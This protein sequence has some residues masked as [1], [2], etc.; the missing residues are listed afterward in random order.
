LELSSTRRSTAWRSDGATPTAPG[1]WALAAD[2]LESATVKTPQTRR[3]LFTCASW[4]VGCKPFATTVTPRS[5]ESF[6]ILVVMASAR[7][8]ADLIQGHSP[9]QLIEPVLDDRQRPGRLIDVP[10]HHESLSIRADVVGPIRHRR[11]A[12][13]V[14]RVREQP[15]ARARFEL[16][17]QLDGHRDQSAGEITVEELA[18]VTGPRRLA[19]TAS[20]DLPAAL[21]V[22]ERRDVHLELAGLRRAVG[23]PPAVGR[24]LRVHGVVEE[25]ASCVRR[26]NGRDQET[27]PAARHQL[28]ND[29]A[30][31]AREGAGLIEHG[32]FEH[33]LGCAGAVGPLP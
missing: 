1:A 23:Q 27:T 17:R 7:L 11:A 2:A 33:P 21:R 28:G 8:S 29:H 20:G 4:Q 30:A 25:P 19:A 16:R 9:S 18:A 26:A 5:L 3:T 31:V 15:P 24:Q 32:A 10:N 6:V 13:A 14:G 12:A 22:R